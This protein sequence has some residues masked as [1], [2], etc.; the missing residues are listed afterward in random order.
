M[1]YVKKQP[2]DSIKEGDRIQVGNLEGDVQAIKFMH[3][4]VNTVTNET[5]IIPNSQITETTVHN[6]SYDDPS[7]IVCNTVQVSYGSDLDRVGEV[8]LEVAGR[9]PYAVAGARH[10]Y[11]V[12]SFDDSGITVRICVVIRKAVERVPAFSWTNNYGFSVI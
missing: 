5:I 10:R 11:Q 9:N 4:V 12:W 1:A 7:I 3:T 2:I 6:Y 8:L